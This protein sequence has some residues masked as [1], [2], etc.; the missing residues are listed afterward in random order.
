MAE[1]HKASDLIEGRTF[2]VFDHFLV[3]NGKRYKVVAVH[4]MDTSTVHHWADC[5]PANVLLSV[6]EVTR[7]G[8]GEQHKRMVTPDQ[9]LEAIEVA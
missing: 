5:D 6:R 7:Y 2:Y 4:G 3:E 8:L 1:H 9:K